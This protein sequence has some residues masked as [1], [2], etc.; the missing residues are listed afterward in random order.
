MKVLVTG[1]NGQLGRCLIDRLQLNSGFEFVALDKSRLD[2]GDAAQ[3]D[4][5]LNE[6]N[7]DVVINAAAYTAVDRAEEEPELA[8]R[9]NGQGAEN[10]ARSAARLDIALIHVSTDYVFDGKADHPYKESDATMPAGVYGQTKLA[11][12]KEVSGCCP[13]HIILRT[14]WVY[15]EYGHNFVK[16]MLRLAAT[17]DELNVVA[18]QI[19]C[20]TYAGDIADAIL[21]ICLD[22]SDNPA[23]GIYHYVGATECSWAEFARAVFA[24]ARKQG[25]LQKEVLVHDIPTSEYPTLAERP[26]YSVLDCKKISTNFA[27]IP[28]PLAQ[29]LPRVLESLVSQ[30]DY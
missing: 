6:V 4:K 20:P 27:V 5:T 8:Q 2:I 26:K 11:G 23:W 9:V 18:D 16:T 12:E 3:V 24:E 1:S 28:E 25:I 14:A 29:S 21:K 13:K 30:Q 22:L 7:P 10:L 15:S 17:R 19:G